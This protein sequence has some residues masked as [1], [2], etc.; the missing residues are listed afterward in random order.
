M[1]VS[2]VSGMQSW[3]ISAA[4]ALMQ[5]GQ[6]AETEGLVGE[7]MNKFKDVERYGDMG[8]KYWGTSA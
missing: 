3:R 7:V 5:E 1:C 4:H 8:G 6:G 2:S